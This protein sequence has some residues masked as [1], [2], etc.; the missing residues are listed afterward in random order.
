MKKIGLAFL[1]VIALSACS[2]PVQD[3]KSPCA[4]ADN[5]PCVRRPVNV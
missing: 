4:G 3:L 5:S 2:A 1:A